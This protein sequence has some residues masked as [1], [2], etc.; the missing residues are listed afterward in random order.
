VTS[1]STRIASEATSTITF[2]IVIVP[3]T[4]LRPVGSRRGRR[5]ACRRRRPRRRS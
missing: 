3:S 5:R 4:V 1:S 2:S